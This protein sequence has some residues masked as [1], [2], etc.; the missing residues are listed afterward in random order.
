MELRDY[1]NVDPRIAI[2]GMSCILP[3]SVNIN[4]AW[5]T[6]R[7]GLDHVSDLPADRVDVTAYFHPDKTMKD[8]IYCKRG[9]FIPNFEFEPREFG[10]NM[11]Q[12]EDSD[13]N[14][15]LSLLKVK[16]VLQSANI[17]A[18]SKE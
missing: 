16:E 5:D 13:T 1:K 2:V 12:M 18:F 3:G 17:P 10:L 9:G 7:S 6:I 8:K 11:L 15:T 4:E 14:Q